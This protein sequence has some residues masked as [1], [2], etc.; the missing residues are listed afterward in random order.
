M[1]KRIARGESCLEFEVVDTGIGIAEDDLERIYMP[2]VQVDDSPTRRQGGTGLGLTLTR[3]IVLLLG[4]T[5]QVDSTVGVGTTFTL[6]VPRR[7]SPNA[8]VAPQAEP[9]ASEVPAA[10]AG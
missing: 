6:T 1:R 3:E 5:I 10:L 8:A 9:V 7:W 4:G 2:F